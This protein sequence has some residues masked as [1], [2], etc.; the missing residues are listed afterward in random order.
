VLDLQNTLRSFR[1]CSVFEHLSCASKLESESPRTKVCEFIALIFIHVTLGRLVKSGWQGTEGRVGGATGEALVVLQHPPPGSEGLVSQ[2][3]LGWLGYGGQST[4]KPQA[5]VCCH[6]RYCA[7]G[8]AICQAYCFHLVSPGVK[9]A[10]HGRTISAKGHSLAC[11]FKS[12]H[13]G[14]DQ[15]FL[16]CCFV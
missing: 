9:R 6:T 10:H 12:V 7:R 14:V 11:I 1:F 3:W 8:A 5:P 15:A 16:F 2:S 13:G 4:F